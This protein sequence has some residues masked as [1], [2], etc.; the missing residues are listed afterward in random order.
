MASFSETSSP[1]SRH[2]DD[3]SPDFKQVT[4]C[5]MRGAKVSR[6]CRDTE[7]TEHLQSSLLWIFRTELKIKLGGYAD[8]KTCR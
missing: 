3:L 7:I 5:G 4:K 1:L 8:V 2:N 6:T